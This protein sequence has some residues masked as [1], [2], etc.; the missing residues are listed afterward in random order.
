MLDIRRSCCNRTVVAG[1]VTYLAEGVVLFGTAV[2]SFATTADLLAHINCMREEEMAS[3]FTKR[4]NERMAQH[5]VLAFGTMSLF[6]CR[7][8]LAGVQSYERSDG[9]QLNVVV[10]SVHNYCGR[11]IR[12]FA[13]LNATARRCE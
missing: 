13:T 10:L 3:E 5:K 12:G 11:H 6:V 9:G 8:G 4:A 1:G 7:T 2:G